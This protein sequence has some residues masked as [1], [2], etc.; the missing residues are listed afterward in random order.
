MPSPMPLVEPVTNATLPDNMVVFFS[1]A[2]SMLGAYAVFRAKSSAT[3]RNSVAVRSESYQS[4][5]WMFPVTIAAD[6]R[7]S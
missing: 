1:D 4:R 5:R 3:R 7:T 2:L 6:G